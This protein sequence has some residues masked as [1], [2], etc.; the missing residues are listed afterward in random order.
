MTTDERWKINLF[1]AHPRHRIRQ[2]IGWLEITAVHKNII[3]IT[4]ER[5]KVILF[6]AHHI[7]LFT[8]RFHPTR[9][10]CK[11]LRQVSKFCDHLNPKFQ[12]YVGTGTPNLLP[13][14]FQLITFL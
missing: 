3:M 10:S 9:P 1:I 6:I 13:I 5:W 4:D 2:E 11:D 12:T 14:L 7:D 8:V